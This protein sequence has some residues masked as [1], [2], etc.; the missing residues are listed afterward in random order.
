MRG[1]RDGERK[2]ERDRQGRSRKAG[3]LAPPAALVNASNLRGNCSRIKS[4][5][6][7]NSSFACNKEILVIVP[8]QAPNYQ[9][10][11]HDSFNAR[12][13]QPISSPSLFAAFLLALGLQPN[14]RNQYATSVSVP[15]Y[16]RREIDGKGDI[17][18]FVY[19][20]ELR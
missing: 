9:G 3:F 20:R 6:T 14:Q 1:R 8:M 13:H 19:P 5:I 2:R 4:V 7:A 17:V 11:A 18:Y 10:A 16:N 15:C 12:N